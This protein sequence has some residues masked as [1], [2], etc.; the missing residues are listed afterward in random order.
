MKRSG[1]AIRRIFSGSTKRASGDASVP[2]SSLSHNEDNPAPGNSSL[3]SALRNLR[4]HAGSKNGE[5][6]TAPSKL[7]KRRS[8]RRRQRGPQPLNGLAAEITSV[9]RANQHLMEPD[10]EPPYPLSSPK[11]VPR[12]TADEAR[13]AERRAERRTALLAS[14]PKELLEAEAHHKSTLGSFL[15]A[16]WEKLMYPADG[17]PEGRSGSR[18]MLG[19]LS[20]SGGPL[21]QHLRKQQRSIGR[22]PLSASQASLGSGI[23]GAGRKPWSGDINIDVYGTKMHEV[24]VGGGG[25][26]R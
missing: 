19:R 23:Q 11:R 5:E 1:R 24:K 8:T 4:G 3:R 9:F 21:L 6:N 10:E 18:T 13:E 17:K 2:A 7:R 20:Q 22:I 16:N 26:K 12:E 25:V 14:L 15:D